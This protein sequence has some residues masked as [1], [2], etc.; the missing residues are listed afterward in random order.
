MDASFKMIDDILS[1]F[2]IE[3]QEG[4]DNLY[5]LIMQEN[6]PVLRRAGLAKLNKYR[7]FWLQGYSVR[8]TP[9]F[10]NMQRHLNEMQSLIQND[11]IGNDILKLIEEINKQLDCAMPRAY[12][13]NALI[14]KT[15]HLIKLG[16]PVI[17]METK[18]DLIEQLNLAI[19]RRNKLVRRQD[20]ING[21]IVNLKPYEYNGYG[22]DTALIVNWNCNSCDQK[23][24]ENISHHADIFAPLECPKC[25]CGEIRLTKSKKMTFWQRCKSKL[26]CCVI[27]TNDGRYQSGTDQEYHP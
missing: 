20:R 8:K 27:C 9:S 7:D 14:F 3:F 1:C 6:D 19:T 2:I 5:L 18:N 15:I 21:I 12:L 16:L 26:M 22:Y 13:I 11:N 24:F 17:P 4:L 10:D 23:W 25:K